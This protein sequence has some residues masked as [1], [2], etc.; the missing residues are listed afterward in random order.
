MTGNGRD[1]ELDIVLI[2]AKDGAIIRN[3][4]SGFDQTHGLRVPGDAGRPLELGAVDVV[5]ADQGDRLAYFVRTEKDRSL[6]VQNVVTRKIEVRIPLTTVDAP[7]SPDFS[8]DGKLI[9][10][11]GMRE[12]RRR[13]L[14]DQSRD[15]GDR[16][17]SRRT[18]SPSYAPTWAPDGKSIV[19]LARVSGNEKLFRMDADG[20][21]PTQLTFGTH[22]DG[23][24]QFLDA[25][26]LVFPSTAV[27][28]AEP[29]DP[30]VAKNGQ[31]YNLWTLDLKTNELKQFTDA[32]SGNLSPGRAARRR[33]VNRLAF[34]TYL[35]GDYG[36]HIL[37][38]KEEITKVAS[39]D[40]G[41]PGP[42]VDFQA[43]LM[44]TLVPDNKKKKGKFEK[45]FLE[46]R[47]PVALGVTSGGDVF[48]GTQVTFTDVLGDQQFNLFVSS[49]SQY[50][51]HVA[52]VAEHGAALAVGV[53]GLLAD[54]S[55]TTASS[56]ASFYDP[57]FSRLHRSRPGGRDAHDAGGT[58]F[59]IYPFN[60]YRR[61]EVSTAA[62]TSTRRSYNDPAV[63]ASALDS[64]SRSRSTAASC[65]TTA[66]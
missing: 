35:K 58:A 26:T 20:A 11:S 49:V 28:P 1:R 38:R 2:S 61:V 48:G 57:A 13:H 45:M 8:P 5:V 62:S 19:Y 59:A 31:I 7:E 12:Q 37:E 3:L 39:S 53:A 4:T 64:T 47:P 34:V 9:A 63:A 32:L 44:H 22:D 18:S 50:R 10:F 27:N 65:S 52:H 15:Q 17:T 25:N 23:G 42:I 56:R 21:N 33:R 29:I 24:A 51:T 40:F 60:R 36:L 6:I 55:S 66:T 46:G 43:P 16:A 41:A 54:R 30:E 14:H